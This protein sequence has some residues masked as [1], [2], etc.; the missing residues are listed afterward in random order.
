M[1]DRKL[2]TLCK[3]YTDIGTTR[4]KN[5]DYILTSE[6][7]NIY[8]VADGIGGLEGGEIASKIAAEQMFYNVRSRSPHGDFYQHVLR[9]TILTNQYV[10]NYALKRFH[11]RRMGTTLTALMFNNSKYIVSHIGDSRCYLFRDERLY[12]ITNDQTLKMHLK[13]VSNEHSADVLD[14]K[15]HILTQA[16]GIKETCTPIL[17]QNT[18]EAGDLFMLCTDGL[19]NTLAD[20]E[21]LQVFKN[22]SNDISDFSEILIE[23][24][25]ARH[26]GDNLSFI[27]VKVISSI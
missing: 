18:T 15:K 20:D 23:M 7:S 14:S 3:S 16:I 27:L 24:S 5:Q 25:M 10:Y 8:I 6:E 11:G 9:A 22:H 17:N 4:D 12:P 19:Y 21:L 1:V 2:T 26:R 13:K